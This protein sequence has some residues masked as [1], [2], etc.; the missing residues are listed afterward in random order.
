M[1]AKIAETERGMVLVT[2]V[3]GSGKS[4]TMAALIN[5]I[6][7][8]ENRHILTL[9]NPIEFLHTRH[10]VVDH[11]ARDRLGHDRLQDG[12]ARRAASGSGRDHDRRDARRRDGRHGDQSGGDGAP[13]DVDAAHARRPEHDPPHHGDVPARGAGRHPHSSGRVAVRGRL[14]APAAQASR[15]RAARS[16]PRS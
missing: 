1:L 3:T 4:S 13:A 16:P 2:G 15:A 8:R 9:E 7:A 11:A 5:Y 12:S 14:A 10:A 6:N